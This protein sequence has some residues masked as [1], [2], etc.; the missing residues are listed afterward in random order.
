[1]TS[2]VSAWL[3]ITEPAMFGVNFRF[4]YPFIAAIT[5]SAIAGAAV[6]MLSEG[7]LDRGRW[8]TGHS[9]H[10]TGW[11]ARICHGDGH[12]DRHSIRLDVRH[13]ACAIEINLNKTND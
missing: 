7:G 4:K 3:G 1:M 10:H 5:G 2:W 12:R 8:C 9:V 11:V 6:T 13:L